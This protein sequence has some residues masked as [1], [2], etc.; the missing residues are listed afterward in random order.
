MPDKEEHQNNTR[1]SDRRAREG[2]TKTGERRKGTLFFFA[3]AIFVNTEMS[4]FLEMFQC[5]T[6][7]MEDKKKTE[8]KRVLERERHMM[9]TVPSESSHSPQQVCAVLMCS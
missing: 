8:R 1:E 6:A 4:L 5:P 3:C 2:G 7:K 9:G